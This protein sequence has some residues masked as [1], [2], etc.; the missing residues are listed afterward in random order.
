MKSALLSVTAVVAL[1]AGCATEPLSGE[2]GRSDLSATGF[3]A[4]TSN[5][6][7]VQTG[8]TGGLIANLNAAFQGSTRD[9]VNFAF[10]R[11]ELDGEARAIL[12]QQAAWIRSNPGIRFRVYGHADLV[13]TEGYNQGLG[14]RRAQNV[15]NYLVS[16]GVSRG[17]LQAVSSFGE[18]R[19]VIATQNPERANRRA[20]TE[21]HGL[22]RAFR[23]YDFDGKVADRL[24]DGYVEGTYGEGT[25]EGG[26]EGG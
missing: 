1:V 19:P 23:G 17:M 7:L 6:L 18:T 10:N 24:Y 9:T 5:N 12:D 2:A 21:V 4:S 14:L 11:A 25:G 13:G 3:G 16:R 15:V 8:A 22:T 26:G 20:V